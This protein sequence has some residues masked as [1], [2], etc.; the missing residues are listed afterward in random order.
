MISTIFMSWP[1]TPTSSLQWDFFCSSITMSRCVNVVVTQQRTVCIHKSKSC[2]FFW[3]VKLHLVS[4]REQLKCLYLA[5]LC[6]HVHYWAY[7][8][9]ACWEII[10]GLLRRRCSNRLLSLCATIR[11][12]RHTHTQAQKH[13]ASHA[14][15]LSAKDHFQVWGSAPTPHTY[16]L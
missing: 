13:T 15:T 7:M 16:S 9:K 8:C 6:D 12:R 2:H 10:S 11:A 5:R 1:S 14:P 3:W 4:N